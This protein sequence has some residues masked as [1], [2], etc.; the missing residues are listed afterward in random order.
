MYHS[1]LKEGIRSVSHLTKLLLPSRKDEYW[2]LGICFLL[3]L[4][5]G[6]ILALYSNIIDVLEPYDNYFS[7]DNL[8]IYRKGYENYEGHSLLRLFT[9]IPFV[10]GNLLEQL[11][12]FK[13]KTL[14]WI[15]FSNLCIS[16]SVMYVY[17]YL[18]DITRIPKYMLYMLSVFYA[19]FMTNIILSFTPESFPISAFLLTFSIY[20]Y[21]LHIVRNEK[22]PYIHSLILV[23]S[24]GGVTGPNF[25][26]GIIPLLFARKTW[27]KLFLYG[28]SLTFIFGVIYIA[29]M[30][31]T[32]EY[33]VYA[34]YWRF[35]RFSVV[36]A[37]HTDLFSNIFHLF[38]GAPVLFPDIFL[39][40]RKMIDALSFDQWWQYSFI[41]LLYALLLLS[42][43]LNWKNKFVQMI[44]LL[45]S[46]DVFI[47]I[48]FQWGID[49]AI[50]FGAHWVYIIPLLLGWLYHMLKKKQR[51]VFNF[52]MAVLFITL[53]SN[54]I[55]HL[56]RFIQKAIEIF[57]FNS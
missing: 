17:R 43:I 14:L 45:F 3:Y 33:G 34:V 4:S 13:A 16:L 48:I 54:N 19:F 12:H 22:I 38:F 6:I 32:N 21:S 35:T 9:F 18:R 7:F 50:L 55:I 52:F 39:N 42:V 36:A 10:V 25:V 11:I 28:V 57:P 31:Y 23:V 37:E 47:H 49:E 27:K 56:I 29:V 20:Y 1:K 15:I 40:E 51:L 2:L 46:V 24:L 53:L 26:K 30:L 8:T 41:I 5:F 44:V